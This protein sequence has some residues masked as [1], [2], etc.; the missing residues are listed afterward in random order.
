MKNATSATYPVSDIARDED[1]VSIVEYVSK[2]G[3]FWVTKPVKGPS[4]NYDFWCF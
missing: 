4:V 3:I 1:I 2:I